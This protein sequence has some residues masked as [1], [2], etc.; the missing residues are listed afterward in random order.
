MNACQATTLNGGFSAAV[1]GF[2]AASD[3]NFA[4]NFCDQTQLSIPFVTQIKFGGTYTLGYGF[5]LGGTF[6]SYPGTTNFGSGSTYNNWLPVNLIATSANTP[7]TKGQS[8]TIPLIYPGSAYL[9]RWNQ[10]D[11]RVSR[12]FALPQRGTVELQVDIFNT[13]NAHPILSESTAYGS[14]LGVPTG[15]LQSRLISFGAQFHF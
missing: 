15:I 8:E 6:Q 2:A 9:P 10:L 3:P 5:N 4:G 1:G 12:R 7:L 13:L 14:Q 11:V